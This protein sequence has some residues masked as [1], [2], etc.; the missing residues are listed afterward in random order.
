MTMKIIKHFVITIVINAVLLYVV[1]N[2]I[3]ELGF[4]I[5]SVYQDT[6]IIFGALGVGFWIVNSLLRSI[7][8]ALTLP[9]K[10]M[11]LGIS[12]L[13]INVLLLYVFEQLINYADVGITVHLGTLSQTFILSLIVTV[14][15]LIV[16][17]VI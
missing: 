17:K 6:L 15:H 2:H 16:K 10:Y 14:I 12:G 8:K 4:K 13:V 5:S 3:P 11:T 7:L 1:A 9:I